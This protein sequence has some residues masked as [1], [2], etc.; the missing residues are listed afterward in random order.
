MI[1]GRRH[2]RLERRLA[3][4]GAPD[5]Q[6]AEERAWHV[7]RSAYAERHSAPPRRRVRRLVSVP[8]ALLVAGVLALSP[9]GASVRHWIVQ[10]LGVPHAS[11]SLFSLPASGRILVSGPGGTWTVAA[12][13]VKR[14]IGPWRDAAWSPRGIYV[15]VA[16]RTSLEAVDARGAPSWTL[17]RPAIR[18]P[19]WFSPSGYRIAYLSATTLRVIA[20]DGTSDR[21][22]ASGVAL[23]APAWRAG[24]PYQLAFSTR[25][26]TIIVAN[27]DTGRTIWSRGLPLAPTLL[28]W[29]ADGSRLLVVTATAAAVYDAT[30]RLSARIALV[31]GQPVRDAALSPDGHSLALLHAG[32][33]DLATLSPGHPLASRRVFSGSGLRQLTWSPDGHWLLVSW[34]P[35]NQWIFIHAAGPPRIIAA[36]RIAQQFA[37]SAATPRFP[38]ISGWCC[39]PAGAAG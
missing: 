8:S 22:L 38:H 13:G 6:L 20:G 29:S 27:A 10:S 7:V 37:P 2:A 25:R 17:A 35:A 26:G 3:Q 5:E 1:G 9:A 33:V 4:L 15:A 28:A 11:S 36:S 32:E 12:N 34:P 23:I 39:T 21:A 18:D 24:H 31:P 30:G 14:R 19:R 16:N